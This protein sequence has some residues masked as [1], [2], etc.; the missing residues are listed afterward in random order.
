[1]TLKEAERLLNPKTS[2]EAISEIKYYSGFNSKDKVI[3]SIEEACIIACTALR[4]KMEL[5]SD[6]TKR[7]RCVTCDYADKSTEPYFCC[8]FNSPT[9]GRDDW[10]YHYLKEEK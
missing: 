6:N 8:Y 7:R 5:R 9:Y 4:E 2:A 3:K 1:M 10:C